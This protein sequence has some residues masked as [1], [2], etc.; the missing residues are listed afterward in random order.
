VLAG[1]GGVASAEAGAAGASAGNGGVP[2]EPQADGGGGGGELL[3]EGGAQAGSDAGGA[4]ACDELPVG[5][6]VTLELDPVDPERVTN[7]RW[8]ASDDSVGDNLSTAGGT[9]TC[10]DPI[11]YFGQAYGA[12]GTLP[13]PVVAGDLATL[14]RCAYRATITSAPA[15]CSAAAQFPVTTEYLQFR[16]ARASQLRI[17][18]RFGFGEAG[19]AYGQL[20]LRPYVP[21]PPLGVF[22]QVIYPNEAN[23]AITVGTPGACPTDCLVTEGATWSG[24]WFADLD[25]TSGQALIVLRDP[26]MTSP[27]SLAINNDGLSGSNITSFLLLAPNGGWQ[28]P[29]TEVEYLCFADPLSWPQAARDAA[30]LPAGCGP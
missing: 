15:N 18:R 10:G 19:S 29:I 9:L 2:T 25:P 20:I 27:A 4:P 23:D 12:E 30:Q 11:E 26:A 24:R 5:S 17:T 28:T 7:L 6:R 14:A 21:R 1:A 13:A 3:S 8:Q 22:S 16:G